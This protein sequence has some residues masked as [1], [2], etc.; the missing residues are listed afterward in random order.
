ME[1]VL[2]VNGVLGVDGVEGAPP[3]MPK[4]SSQLFPQ[5]Y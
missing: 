1:G 2:G 3:I 5:L 4:S